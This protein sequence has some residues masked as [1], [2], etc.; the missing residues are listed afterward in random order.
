MDDRQCDLAEPA[1]EVSRAEAVSDS[2]T[3]APRWNTNNGSDFRIDVLIYWAKRQNHFKGAEE[4]DRRETDEVSPAH[5]STR[6]DDRYAESTGNSRQGV[7][8]SPVRGR[9]LHA[10]EI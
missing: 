5:M 10:P 6:P 9:N 1:E 4:C 3:K 2:S 8:N 7:W